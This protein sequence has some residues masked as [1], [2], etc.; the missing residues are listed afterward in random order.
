MNFDIY[1]FL[2]NIKSNNIELSSTG[3]NKQ[4]LIYFSSNDKKK[5]YFT[6]SAKEKYLYVYSDEYKSVTS[7]I[8]LSDIELIDIILTAINPDREI[9]VEKEESAEV[10]ETEEEK[11]DR[12]LK[13][14]FGELYL[15][16]NKDKEE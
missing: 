13:E 12:L 15:I 3:D 5:Y 9:K 11:E 14:E 1:T 2:D 7:K 6:Y 16:E 4:D 8:K 10:V